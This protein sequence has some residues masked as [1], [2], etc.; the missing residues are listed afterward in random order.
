MD[1]IT[2]LGKQIIADLYYCDEKLLNNLDHVRRI[3][4]EAA[5]KANTQII[6]H[7]FHKFKPQ[8]VSGVVVIAES[9]VAIHTWPEYGYAA[10]DIFTCGNRSMPRLA[11]RH[12]SQA[13]KAKR[14]RYREVERG[15]LKHVQLNE[16]K[17]FNA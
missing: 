2:C 1:G 7:K 11:L 10:V 17:I 4:I 6:D 9:H 14:V 12:I 3:M 8:G 13:L 16:S 15:V 5:E